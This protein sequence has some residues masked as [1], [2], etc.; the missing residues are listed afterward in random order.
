MSSRV[1]NYSYWNMFLYRI[2]WCRRRPS[3]GQVN[4]ERQWQSTSSTSSAVSWQDR[5]LHV[6][7]WDDIMYLKLPVNLF[8][9]GVH[10]RENVCISDFISFADTCVIESSKFDV[11]ETLMLALFS[12]ST[13]K[14]FGRSFFFSLIFILIR[15]FC[16]DIFPPCF[17]I[18]KYIV[19]LIFKLN[20]K[21]SAIC[22]FTLAPIFWGKAIVARIAAISYS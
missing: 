19:F 12:P 8:L 18:A 17:D 1:T 20:W 2:R 9:V 11:C 22:F 4:R 21:T 5:P 13:R 10:E 14:I 3:T 16:H 6:G 7:Y 15:L